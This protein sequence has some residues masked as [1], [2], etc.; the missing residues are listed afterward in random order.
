MKQVALALLAGWVIGIIFSWL[1]LP[2]PAPPPLG[3]VGALGLTL[4]DIF[5]Q[6]LRKFLGGATTS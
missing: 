6:W 1:K 2:L 4:G 5:F 3:L